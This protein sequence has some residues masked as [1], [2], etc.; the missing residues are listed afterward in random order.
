MADTTL[1]QLAELVVRF[2]DERDWKQ[3]H[4]LK[5]VAI[6]L[7]LEAAELLELFQWRSGS[8]LDAYLESNRDAVSDELSDILYWVL[9]M[10]NDLGIDLG[11][12]FT[13]KMAANA[14]K[15]PVDRA[16]GSKRKYTDL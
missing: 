15:Y 6:S 5:D 3:F 12:A 2:R 7:N 4:N 14:E 16:K 10:S 13:R 11:A 9:L 8:E 1:K